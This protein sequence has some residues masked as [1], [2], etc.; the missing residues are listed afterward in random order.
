M[1][2]TGLVLA[3]VAV[4]GLTAGFASAAVR[5]D[6]SVGYLTEPSDRQP[7]DVAGDYL[8]ANLDALGLVAGDLDGVIVTDHY[9]TQ[10]NGVTHIYLR[11]TLDGVQVINANLS[12][13][14][15]GDGRIINYGG[16]FFGDLAGNVNA[17]SPRLTPEQAILAAAA[18]VGLPSEAELMHLSSEAGRDMGS[19]FE[20]P[21]LSI[22]QIPVRLR[23]FGQDSG[24]LRLVW[25]TRLRLPNG[26]HW[27]TVW[28]DAHS[29]RALEKA[30]WIARDSYKVF[31]YPR[32]SPNDGPQ[33]LEVD[34]AHPVGSPFGWHD[35][36][37]APG[38]E[39]TDTRG[40]NVEAQEDQDANN[41]P[42]DRVDGG[43]N[44]VFDIDFQPE[45]QPADNIEQAIV[46]LFYWNN[47]THDLMYLY[48]FDEAAGNF[49]TNNYGNGGN[50][51]RPR[52]G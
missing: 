26:Q 41:I 17:V 47:V 22:E 4:L 31:A 10:H 48:G 44:L 19:L 11:Q 16:R 42:G 18:H 29:G 52:A 20:A 34:P 24:E 46:N 13:N 27:W 35:T 45:L 23:Y 37:G 33:T 9:G 8:R 14:V 15:A 1:K 30:D 7:L 51:R 40:N 3:L 6:G 28:V 25:E 43:P 12:I 2:R 50:E 5:P 36:D 39:F 49:Q 21:V 38:E 32:E